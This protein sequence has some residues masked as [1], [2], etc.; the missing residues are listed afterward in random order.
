MRFTL[1]LALIIPAATA[2]QT[3]YLAT[4]SYNGRYGNYLAFFSDSDACNDGVAFGSIN[5]FTYCD[6]PL[7]LLGHENIT[8]T[9]CPNPGNLPTGVADEGAP[10]LTCQQVYYPPPAA[11]YDRCDLPGK[12]GYVSLLLYCS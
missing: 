10:A 5:T 9:G 7:T 11:F 2:L 4:L 8:F 3:I 6:V 1:P 12:G